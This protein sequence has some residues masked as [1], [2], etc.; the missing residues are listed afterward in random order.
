MPR[1]Y[2]AADIRQITMK[3]AATI[4]CH[5]AIIDA[6]MMPL[7]LFFMFADYCHI[8]PLF[9]MF[10]CRFIGMP[11][12]RFSLLFAAMRAFAAIF[13]RG[14]RYVYYAIR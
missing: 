11:R 2:C 13:T 8:L 10:R 1:V 5:Y 12:L 7:P 3:I 14:K 6:A 9:A 4:A